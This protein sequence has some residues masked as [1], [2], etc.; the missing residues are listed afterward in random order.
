MRTFMESIEVEYR[1]YRSTAEAAMAQLSDEELVEVPVGTV[2]SRI[3]RG[4]GRLADM[5]APDGTEPAAGS[6]ESLEDR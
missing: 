4:R 6:S 1:R 3:A 2:R 5:L